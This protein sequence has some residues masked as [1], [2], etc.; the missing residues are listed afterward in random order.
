VVEVEVVSGLYLVR[1]PDLATSLG[2]NVVKVCGCGYGTSTW[3]IYG[4]VTRSG[5]PLG[6]NV[7]RVVIV[8]IVPRLSVVQ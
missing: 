8:V 3:I 4:T 2:G 5:L 6:G 7:V 1:G